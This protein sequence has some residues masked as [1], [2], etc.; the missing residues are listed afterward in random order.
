MNYMVQDSTQKNAST[1]LDKK[2]L[3][4]LD[5]L[6]L[7]QYYLW[8]MCWLVY[9][10]LTNQYINQNLPSVWRMGKIYGWLLISNFPLKANA[11]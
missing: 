8:V 5:N 10:K 4:R 1:F 6:N 7:W 9:G 11:H 2:V 3:N